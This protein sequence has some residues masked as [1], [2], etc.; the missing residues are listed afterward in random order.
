MRIK[1][2]IWTA[3]L[4]V[5]TAVPA[6]AAGSMNSTAMKANSME[7]M[8]SG[9]VV[10]IM[11]DGHMGTTTMSGGKMT[12]TINM[13]KPIS[14]CLM[15]ISGKGGKTYQVDTSGSK[16]TKECQGIAK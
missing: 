10:A 13:S 1:Q 6:A 4:V 9:E 8:K 7:T 15:F 12:S 2:M 16:A 5:A 3:G 14:H 11:P